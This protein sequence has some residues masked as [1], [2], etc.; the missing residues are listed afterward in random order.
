MNCVTIAEALKPAG[1]Y[2]A[3]SGKW[4]VGST[5]EQWPRKRG[6]D[7]FYG[8]P[9]G[10]GHHYRMLPGRQLVLDDAAIE[11]LDGWYTTT[12][13]LRHRRGQHV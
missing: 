13:Q 9:E 3:I 2:T 6:F 11:V 4:H 10:G 1:Y 12:G 5:P 8:I 7:R